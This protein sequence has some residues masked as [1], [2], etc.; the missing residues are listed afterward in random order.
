MKQ[1]PEEKISEA[2]RLLRGVAHELRL[3]ILCHLGE[4]PLTVSEIMALTGASQS[5]LSQHL[6]K[7]RMMGL[8]RCER[9]SQQVLYQLADPA[10][11]QIIEA[12]KGIYCS[13]SD[14]SDSKEP[15]NNSV[16]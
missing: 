16:E 12:L 7:M 8:L 15:L 1:F 2:T 10:F 3:S 6:A 5:N 11:A 14:I 13:S 9:K 4:G